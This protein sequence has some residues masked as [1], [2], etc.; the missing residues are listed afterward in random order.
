MSDKKR[1]DVALVERGLAQSRDK[2]QALVR[3]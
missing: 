1:I 3:G 2:A